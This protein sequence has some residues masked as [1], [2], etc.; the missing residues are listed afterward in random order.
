MSTTSRTMIATV[1]ALGL[2]ASVASSSTAA[3]PARSDGLPAVSAGPRPGPAILYSKP[4]RAPQLENTGAWKAPPILVSGTDAYRSGEWIY[5][6]YLFDDHGATGVPDLNT[7]YGAGTN[8]FSPTAGDL[9][10]D[11]K[12]ELVSMTREGYLMA[13][14]T[15]GV[16]AGLEWWRAGAFDTGALVGARMH[17]LLVGPDADTQLVRADGTLVPVHVVRWPL[18]GVDLTAVVVIE[19]DAAPEAPVVD[20]VWVAELERLARIG[21]WSFDLAS[22]RLE[23][24]ETGQRIRAIAVVLAGVLEETGA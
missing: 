2:M 20:P 4:P 6:D 3:A 19:R 10:G 5:Q 12:V 16:P 22:S 9:L 21:T 15:D 14:K 7:P 17:R 13:W 18:L 23:R 11:G 24:S 8:L 1:L